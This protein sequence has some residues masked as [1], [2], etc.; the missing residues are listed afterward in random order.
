MALARAQP[1]EGDLEVAQGCLGAP[2]SGS[3][4]RDDG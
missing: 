2:L 1:L 4:E 3:G